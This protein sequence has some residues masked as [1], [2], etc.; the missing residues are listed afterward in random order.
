M[1]LFPIIRTLH[2]EW[3]TA[4]IKSAVMTTGKP[5]CVCACRADRR[6]AMDG[7]TLTAVSSFCEYT[8]TEMDDRG[9]LILKASSLPPSPFGYGAGRVMNQGLVY[10]LGDAD[11]PGF[12]CALKYNAT[13][14]AT[15]N[16]AP[17][18]CPSEAATRP[19]PSSTSPRRAPRR[20]RAAQGQERRQARHVRPSWP[21]PLASPSW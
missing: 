17:Y 4:A 10:D 6:F 12:L 8:A 19:S 2:P 1:R 11:H 14:M 16:G 21:S 18:T 3:N 20:G 5:H 7:R 13:A 9:D 15:F